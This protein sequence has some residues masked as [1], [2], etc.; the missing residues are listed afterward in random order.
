MDSIDTVYEYFPN[1]SSKQKL[2]LSKLFE[3]YTDW[4]EKINVIS[5]QDMDNFHIRHVLHS[6]AIAKQYQ[7]PIN[8]HIID[9]G[10]GGGFPSIPLA[11]FFPT[12]KFTIVDSVQKKM[13][14]A[15][16]VIS[17]LKLENCS[18]STLRAEQIIGT[19]DIILGRA[20]TKFTDFVNLTKHL[21]KP[22]KEL[23]KG[24]IYYLK[25]GD[26]SEDLAKYPLLAI[27]ELKDLFNEDFFKEE[28]KLLYLDSAT[29][30]RPSNPR[31]SS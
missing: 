25:G 1:L 11:I 7:F 18:T 13:K 20:V 26:T 28:K 6:L 19:Y 21:L 9:I 31:K 27:T 23:N 2:Q 14:V 12:C 29:L 10:A 3:L 24:G 4:N 17:E 30:A 8:S 22:Q 5:R 16:A 15:D